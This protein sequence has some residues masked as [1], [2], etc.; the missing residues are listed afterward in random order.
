MSRRAFETD[1]GCSC[2]HSPWTDRSGEHICTKSRCC[3][4]RGNHTKSWDPSAARVQCQQNQ[5]D[6]SKQGL[7]PFRYTSIVV[8]K[9]RNEH[10]RRQT[11][12]Q[13]GFYNFSDGILDKSHKFIKNLFQ[14]FMV[15]SIKAGSLLVVN[16]QKNTKIPCIVG[17]YVTYKPLHVCVF[18]DLSI[19]IY[20]KI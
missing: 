10:R 9:R 5:Q 3:T 16:T 20:C 14:V 6:P 2:S 8:T 1:S 11:D 15:K 13:Y 7:C 17:S 19:K 12:Y 4:W 18:I